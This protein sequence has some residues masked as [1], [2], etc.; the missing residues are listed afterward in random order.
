[1]VSS[2]IRVV[3]GILNK[4][5]LEVAYSFG[6]SVLSRSSPLLVSLIAARFLSEQQFGGFSIVLAILAS[7]ASVSASGVGVVCNKETSEKYQANP[8]YV[9]TLLVFTVGLC[10]ALSMFFALCFSFYYDADERFAGVWR[11]AYLFFVSFMMTSVGA[12]EGFLYGLKKYRPVFIFSFIVFFFSV[13]SSIFLVVIYGFFGALLA[14]FLFR[15]FQVFLLCSYVSSIVSVGFRLKNIA[16]YYE[17]IKRNLVGMNLP[18]AG[19][20]LLAAPTTAIAMIYLGQHAGLDEVAKFGLAYQ[21]FLVAIF[22]PTA[23]GQY[24]ISRLTGSQLN[25]K[26]MLLK[27]AKIMFAYGFLAFGIMQAIPWVSSFLS[28]SVNID[29][30]LVFA[31]GGAALVYSVAVCFGM[32]WSSLGRGRV[33][34]YGQVGWVF[35]LSMVSMLVVNGLGAVGLGYGFLAAALMQLLIYIF[36]YLSLLE[37]N[38]GL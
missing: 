35:G 8:E 33:I 23:L 28:L 29:S 16:V 1:M 26:N 37:Q 13:F 25:K 30:E 34:F 12:V 38:R 9:V 2:L 27:S 22:P 32:F 24:L 10:C 17:D 21:F 7:V 19:A 5:H 6:H 11:Y 18:L 20:A 36:C 3:F 31:L 14:I 4:K 15:L